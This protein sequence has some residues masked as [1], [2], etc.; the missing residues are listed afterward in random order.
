M[1][2]IHTKKKAIQKLNHFKWGYY[3]LQSSNQYQ[4]KFKILKNKKINS[5]MQIP[6]IGK[7]RER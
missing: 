3:T 2:K 6:L 4:K 1:S 7:K 5:S